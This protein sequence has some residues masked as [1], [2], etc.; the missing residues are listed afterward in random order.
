MK[1]WAYWITSKKLLARWGVDADDL[2]QAVYSRELTM[3]V[4]LSDGKIFNDGNEFVDLYRQENYVSFIKLL[5][6]NLLDQTD[7]RW[8]DLNATALFPVDEVIEFEQKHGIK[9]ADLELTKMRRL[10]TTLQ[11]HNPIL[12]LRSDAN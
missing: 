11:N 7:G 2:A 12:T 3:V 1:P 6:S 5:E 8:P 4:R 10:Q 9:L